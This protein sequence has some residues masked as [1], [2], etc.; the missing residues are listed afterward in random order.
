MLFGKPTVPKPLKQ[1]FLDPVAVDR[2]REI[3]DDPVFQ[4]ACATLHN[5][6]LPSFN[7]V[8]NTPEGNSNRLAWLA[9]YRDFANDLQSLT[10][11]PQTKDYSVAE[12][13][14]IQ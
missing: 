4:V 6:A 8:N 12:W 9:G 7:T 3:L 1:W 14:H 2:L 11:L 5:A 13:E 10:K